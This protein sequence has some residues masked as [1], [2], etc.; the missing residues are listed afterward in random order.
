VSDAP[1]SSLRSPAPNLDYYTPP[2]P[3]VPT[4]PRT[5]DRP[6]PMTFDLNDKVAVVT[7][8]SSGIGAAIATALVSA[9]A[10]VVLNSSSTPREGTRLADRLVQ[11]IYVQG[12]VS[13]PVDAHR[14]VEAALSTWGRLDIL[15]NNAGTTTP[16]PHDD[17]ASASPDVWRRI[18]DVNLI[19]A[20]NL[21]SGSVEPLR[22]AEGSIINISSVAG[23]TASGSSVPY[24]VSKAGLNHMTRLLA[25]ALGPQ[26]TVNAIAPG[27][28]DSPWTK[29]MSDE[30]DAVRRDS[31]L[32]RLGTPE[33]VARAC[34]ALISMRYTTGEV[35][36][37]DGGMHLH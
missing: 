24:S 28:I 2:A 22:A 13:D 25:K 27:F 34:L 12:G 11:A 36:L 17:L 15:V 6:R 33:D 19:G 32:R 10:N 9:G 4:A 5:R 7:G 20:W 35:L 29:D 18:L 16:I 37:V 23:I 3:A 1:N 21:I 31:P 8:S 30:A 14:I 26:I